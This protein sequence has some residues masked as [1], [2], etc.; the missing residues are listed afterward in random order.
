MNV[1]VNI[2]INDAGDNDE[3]KIEV[4]GNLPKSSLKS[5]EIDL[6]VI[7]MSKKKTIE[8]IEEIDWTKTIEEIDW[9]AISKKDLKHS[10]RIL[11]EQCFQKL[12]P[13]IIIDKSMQ[14]I[15]AHG[16]KNDTNLMMLMHDI[17]SQF[18]LQTRMSSLDENG[19]YNGEYVSIRQFCEQSTKISKLKSIQPVSQLLPLSP[20]EQI[21]GCV[22]AYE[23]R[24]MP[25]FIVESWHAYQ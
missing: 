25:P 18:R 10:T 22:K 13:E 6:T 19:D 16:L 14:R 2:N 20:Y 24:T 8:E 17:F 23:N 7:M 21:I 3:Q 5:E 1:N 9:T 11:S 4:D 15:F 12:G